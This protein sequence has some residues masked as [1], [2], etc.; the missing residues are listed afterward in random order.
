MLLVALVWPSSQHALACISWPSTSPGPRSRLCYDVLRSVSA[1]HERA[2]L[3]RCLCGVDRRLVYHLSHALSATQR[4]QKTTHEPAGC[5]PVDADALA[6]PAGGIV[7][8]RSPGGNEI[9]GR[10]ASQLG[11]SPSSHEKRWT[12]SSH[13]LSS[14]AVY[15]RLL[16][17]YDARGLMLGQLASYS[18]RGS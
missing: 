2:L 15:E 3:F 6:T 5:W 8:P 7:P 17:I 10:V 4:R 13:A 11:H 14:G 16:L 12:T 9:T 1:A 18:S